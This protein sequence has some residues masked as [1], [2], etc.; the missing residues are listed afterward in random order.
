MVIVWVEWVG[1][2]GEWCLYGRLGLDALSVIG[3][4]GVQLLYFCCSS[5]LVRV[6]LSSYFITS[7]NLY[8]YVCCYDTWMSRNTSRGP[9]NVY[10]YEPQQNLGRGCTCLKPV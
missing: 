6:L 2:S 7:L 8:L 4:T 3:P 1:Y 10:G 9:N 5:V